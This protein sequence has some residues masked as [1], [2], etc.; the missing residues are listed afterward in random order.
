[1][2]LLPTGRRVCMAMPPREGRGVL[3]VGRAIIEIGSQSSLRQ[4]VVNLGR[5]ACAGPNFARRS[6]LPQARRRCRR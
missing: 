4:F 3:D 5:A 1:M 2:L 6:T